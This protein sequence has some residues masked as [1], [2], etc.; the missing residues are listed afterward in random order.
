MLE[1]DFLYYP[2]IYLE[3]NEKNISM[4]TRFVIYGLA[5]WIIETMFTGFTSLLRGDVT[6]YAFT[7]IWMF[8]IYG[9]AILLEPVHERIRYIPAALR[10]GVYT[11]LIFAGEY[12]TGKALQ[13]LIGRCPWCYGTGPYIFDGII[14]LTFIPVWFVTGLAFEK[15]HDYLVE[16]GVGENRAEDKTAVTGSSNRRRKYDKD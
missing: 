7:Y 15:F 10:G 16:K 4:K 11:V 13:L 5:G 14:T 3:P 2:C 9:L 1:G 6:M 12:L 8:P